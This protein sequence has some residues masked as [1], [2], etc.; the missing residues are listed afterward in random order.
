MI[1]CTSGSLLGG[2]TPSKVEPSAAP[3]ISAADA[4]RASTDVEAKQSGPMSEAQEDGTPKKRVVVT[5]GPCPAGT[6]LTGGVPPKAKELW[7]ARGEVR[8]GPYT[9]WHDSGQIA[10][11]LNY[12]NGQQDGRSVQWDPE[13]QILEEGTYRAGQKTGR[14]KSYREGRLN[15]EGEF[16]D[17]QQHGVFLNFAG[18][19]TKQAE[20]QFQ[21][22]EPCGTFR[23]W[24]WE[25]GKPTKCI[26]LEHAEMCN[27]TETGAE[28]KKCATD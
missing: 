17:G 18:N 9:R 1:L 8:H 7:C 23:C 24:D 26:P 11:Q 6:V 13:G 28:C 10:E 12:V 20:G 22:G 3:K 21:S 2:C 16:K 25:T 14:W 19:G 5:R 27:L 4:E 15:F